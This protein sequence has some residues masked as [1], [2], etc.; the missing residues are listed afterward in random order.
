MGHESLTRM[1][2]GGRHLIKI[3]TFPG[4]GLIIQS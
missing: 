2:G 3:G 4:L 1:T